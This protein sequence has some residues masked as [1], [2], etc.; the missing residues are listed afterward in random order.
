MLCRSKSPKDFDLFQIPFGPVTSWN[1]I[2][3]FYPNVVL[4][5][6][7]SSPDSFLLFFYECSP[8][9]STYR[10]KDEDSENDFAEVLGINFNVVSEGETKEELEKRREKEEDESRIIQM[11]IEKEEKERMEALR[12]FL[13]ADEYERLSN[14]NSNTSESSLESLYTIDEDNGKRK[15]SSKQDKKERRRK[16]VESRS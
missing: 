2:I 3:N 6:D 13:L 10:F 16:L 14:P 15:K 5:M 8:I 4:E 1:E 7:G 12:D 11:R 9:D